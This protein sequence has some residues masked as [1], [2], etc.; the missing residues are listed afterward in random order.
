MAPG[1][2]DQLLIPL[3][4]WTHVACTYDGAAITL[5]QDGAA[6]TPT[7]ATGAIATAGTT[8]MSLGQN[9]PTGDHLAGALDDVRIWRVALTAE[10]IATDAE[11]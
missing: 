8:G 4:T 3:A 1:S 5:Y 10:Q 2:V 11:P 9:L 7:A 6:A